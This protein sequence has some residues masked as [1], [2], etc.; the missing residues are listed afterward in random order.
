MLH[1]AKISC[2]SFLDLQLICPHEEYTQTVPGWC[3]FNTLLVVDT[4][5]TYLDAVYTLMMR[6]LISCSLDQPR[7]S[8][9]VVWDQAMHAKAFEIYNSRLHDRLERIVL[10]LSAFHIII[11]FMAIFGRR[12]GSAGLRDVLIESST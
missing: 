3:G 6:S 2:F 7:P 8:V 4:L 10:R 9:V 11:N 5:S 1:I 12:F